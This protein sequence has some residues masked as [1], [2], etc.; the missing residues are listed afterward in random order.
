MRERLNHLSS[1]ETFQSGND[2]EFSRWAD[3]R[4]D[5]WLVD[6]ALRNGKE[7]TARKIVT[8]KK[9]DVCHFPLSVWTFQV[10]VGLTTLYRLWWMS[11][12]SW[13]FVV[14]KMGFQDTAAS[15]HWR[16]VMRIRLHYAKWRW[17]YLQKKSHKYDLVIV[18]YL[19]RVHWS[20]SFAYK[21]ISNWRVHVGP[22]KLSYTQRST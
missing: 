9:I 3:I 20:S 19:I 13:T 8:E 11:T 1:V 4:L 22:K 14:L 18:P 16:G 7:K 10:E 17:A 5:R 21:N 15:R 6:W 12:C 2:L